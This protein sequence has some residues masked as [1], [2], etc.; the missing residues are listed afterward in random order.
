MD[1]YTVF[2]KKDS[3]EKEKQLDTIPTIFS[4]LTKIVLWNN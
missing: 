1:T 3:T 4:E 2:T